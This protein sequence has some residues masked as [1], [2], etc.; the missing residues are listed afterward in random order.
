MR[1]QG[2]EPAPVSEPLLPAADAYKPPISC[3]GS[4]TDCVT[5]PADLMVRDDELPVCRVD[6]ATHDSALARFHPPNPQ[7]TDISIGRLPGK[8]Q[9][10]D[11][12]TEACACMCPSGVQPCE[13]LDSAAAEAALQEARDASNAAF[14]EAADISRAAFAAAVNATAPEGVEVGSDEYWAWRIETMMDAWD[15]HKNATFD[16]YG[17]SQEERIAAIDALRDMF[18]HGRAPAPEPAAEQGVGGGAVA[19]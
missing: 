10:N 8:P 17:S 9:T 4:I 14:Q 6:L 19:K 18:G 13:A 5:C 1:G 15:T 16:A 12:I 2:I 7:C 3:L 11:W